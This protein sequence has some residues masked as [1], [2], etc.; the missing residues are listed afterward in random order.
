M[1]GSNSVNVYLGIGIPWLAAAIYWASASGVKTSANPGLKTQPT[2]GGLAKDTL[3]DWKTR[4][5]AGRL[6]EATG[7]CHFWK[8]FFSLYFSALHDEIHVLISFMLCPGWARC[9]LYCEV[10]QRRVCG[11]GWSFGIQCSSLQLC[12]DHLPGFLTFKIR[13]REKSK[14]RRIFVQMCNFE[15]FVVNSLWIVRWSAWT[16]LKSSKPRLSFACVAW[17]WVV[18]WAVPRKWHT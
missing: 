2:R 14:W 8:I 13:L 5:T 12:R 7:V 11:A 16:A 1:T 17:P 9:R 15:N 10:F 3:E 4:Y 6:R 18:N